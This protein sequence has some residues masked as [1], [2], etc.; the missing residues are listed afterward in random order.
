LPVVIAGILRRNTAGTHALPDLQ[1]QDETVA[2]AVGDAAARDALAGCEGRLQAL[3][4]QQELLAHGISHDLRAPLRA[5]DNFSALLERQ[6]GDR[7]DETGRGYLQRVRDAA[8]RMDALL[9]ALL[10]FSRVERAELACAPV[11]IGQLAELALAEL[12]EAAPARR[13][14]AGIAPGLVV[15]GDEAQLRIVVGQLLRNA[16]NFS[17]DPVQVA[18]DGEREGELLR[19]CVR[20]RG[21]GFDMR[22]ADKL[23]EPFQRLHGPEQ[24]SGSGLGLAIAKGI[25]DRHGGKLW[26]RSK[27]GEGSTFCLELPAAPTPGQTQ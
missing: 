22:Y 11:D 18:I 25:V 20:D 9:D 6:A 27:P 5:I 4:R 14:Q 3:A 2:P 19:V 23:F 10:E 17:D 8:A 12:Q 26:G 13:V 7:L 24:G 16:W 21:R 1:F 15:L